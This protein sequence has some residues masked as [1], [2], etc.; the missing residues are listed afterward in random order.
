[1]DSF[2]RYVYVPVGARVQ[3]NPVILSKHNGEWCLTN[4][5]FSALALATFNSPSMYLLHFCRGRPTLGLNKTRILQRSRKNP[6]PD[7]SHPVT[8]IGQFHH[9]SVETHGPRFHTSGPSH[10]PGL[11]TPEPYLHSFALHRLHACRRSAT[12]LRALPTALPAR[13]CRPP[14]SWASV[15]ARTRRSR[16]CLV[17]TQARA[18]LLQLPALLRFAGE[19]PSALHSS[20]RSVTGAFNPL[21]VLTSRAPTRTL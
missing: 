17:A 19:L 9:A 11:H 18:W 6:L 7:Q 10:F 8:S 12:A 15:R 16:L 3:N 13:P 4:F 5:I 21:V 14:A 20:S 2:R 1:M